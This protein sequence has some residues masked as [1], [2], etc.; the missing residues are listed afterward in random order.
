MLFLLNSLDPK[1]L[2]ELALLG[3]DEDKSVVL[4]GD[5]AYYAAPAMAPRLTAL[6]FDDIFVCADAL[7]SRNIAPDEAVEAVGYG[8]IAKMI[9]ED[10][11]RVVAL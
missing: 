8:Q 7:E 2:D 4:Y 9:L 10:H 3:G 11:D 1:R 5:A 6:E